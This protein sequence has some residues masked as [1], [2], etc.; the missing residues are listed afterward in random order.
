MATAKILHVFHNSLVN[1][2]YTF[3][4]GK[5]ANFLGGTYATDIQSEIAELNK[6]VKSGHPHIYV[7]PDELTI[8]TTFVDPMEAIKAKIRA[9]LLAE[10]AAAAANKTEDRGGY[11]TSGKLEGIA[12][13]HT[14]Q[15]GAADS[16][17]NDGATATTGTPTAAATV[18]TP[19]NPQ[20]ALTAKLATI[21]AGPTNK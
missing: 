16:T 21:V 5:D 8:D 2:R 13:T 20:A 3:K 10:Q 19:A 7:K 4:N 11:D 15:Q 17:S 12:N 9:E 6:E 18:V 14:I 1:C